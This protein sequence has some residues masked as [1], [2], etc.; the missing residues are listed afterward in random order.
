MQN[1]YT[2]AGQTSFALMMFRCVRYSRCLALVAG[3]FALNIGQTLA[4]LVVRPGS[5]AAG[6]LVTIEGLTACYGFGAGYSLE[7]PTDT[8][9]V[10]VIKIFD[11]GIV[12]PPPLTCPASKRN[13]IAVGPLE[14]GEYRVEYYV[15]GH[16]GGPPHLIET[17]M[18]VVTQRSNAAFPFDWAGLWSDPANPGWG[19]TI[20]R[21]SASGHV[22]VAWYLHE[23]MPG[24]GPRPVWLVASNMTNDGSSELPVLERGLSIKLRGDLAR[25]LSNR[26]FAENPT[27]PYAL[28]Q[29]ELAGR[30]EI[31]FLSSTEARLTWELSNSN[32]FSQ[33]LQAPATGLAR[34]GSTRIFRLAY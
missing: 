28:S 8:V 2:C 7:L 15:T 13:R 30:I 19:I 1:A 10:S 27:S 4:Q 11:R 5:P 32:L 31:E 29:I 9:P 12:L 18:F 21:D 3:L 24:A 16:P 22:F 33:A 20:D 6:S 17:K 34:S 25:G 23:T 14:S 26:A